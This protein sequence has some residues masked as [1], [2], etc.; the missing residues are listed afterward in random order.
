[1]ISGRQMGRSRAVARAVAKNAGI[2]PKVFDKLWGEYEGYEYKRRKDYGAVVAT[3]A[4][5]EVTEAFKEMDK[6]KKSLTNMTS[7]LLLVKQ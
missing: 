7:G 4:G 3:Y 1:M 5:P 6:K 2:P